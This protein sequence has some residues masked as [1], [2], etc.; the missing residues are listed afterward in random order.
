[1][2]INH[3]HL[4]VYSAPKAPQRWSDLEVAKRWLKVYPSKLDSPKFK[5]QRENKLKAIL[6]DKEKLALYRERLGSLSWLMSRINEPIAKK[7]NREDFVTGHFWDRFSLLQNRHTL[8]P[9]K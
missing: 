2:D 4:V 9:C 3:Y 6:K 1:M 7:S 8:H 5:V